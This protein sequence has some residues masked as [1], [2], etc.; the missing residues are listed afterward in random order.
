MDYVTD[1]HSL[2][3][4]FT[5][6][7]RLSSDALKAFQASEEEGTVFV[8]AVV[9]AEIMFIARKGRITISFEDTLKRIEENGS[10]E[11]VP[12]NVEILRAADKIEAD[13]EMHDRL[14]AATA[15]Y[16]N[17]SLIT[18]DETLRASGVVS[19]IW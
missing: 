11:I 1:T 19:T 2:V 8:P 9:L 13:L 16:N 17:S 14:I 18:K 5:D 10:F 6:D 15:L 3:W 12:L 7:S 4:Y